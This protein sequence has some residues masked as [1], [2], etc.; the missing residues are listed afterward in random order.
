MENHHHFL[1]GQ[2]KELSMA[3]FYVENHQHFLAGQIKELQTVNVYQ[4]LWSEFL[5]E[6]MDDLEYPYDERSRS[7]DFFI[8][9]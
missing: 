3:M 8:G 7:M 5:W 4:R 2:I 9:H 1:A 6:S